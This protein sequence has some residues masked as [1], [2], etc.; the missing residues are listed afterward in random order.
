MQRVVGMSCRWSNEFESLPQA[1]FS[2]QLKDSDQLRNGYVRRMSKQN[3]LLCRIALRKLTSFLRTVCLVIAI[4][5]GRRLHGRQI[6]IVV[7]AHKVKVEALTH[8]TRVQYALH[9]DDTHV[10]E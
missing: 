3:R 8:R 9:N 6:S 7:Y 4:R 10:G 2:S 5:C 1:L